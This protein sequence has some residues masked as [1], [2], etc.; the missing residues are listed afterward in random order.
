MKVLLD[1]APIV[2]IMQNRF[3]MSADIDHDSDRA[4]NNVLFEPIIDD[5]LGERFREDL[6]QFGRPMTNLLERV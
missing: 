6:Q 5:V 2:G 3:G 4:E 1:D